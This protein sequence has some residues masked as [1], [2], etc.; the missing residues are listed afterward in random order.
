MRVG[1]ITLKLKLIH[2]PPCRAEKELR[3]PPK[4]ANKR[5]D[6]GHLKNKAT[7]KKMVP[8]TLVAILDID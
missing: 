5:Q 2:K 8:T 7:V 6:I 4:I 3:V 1:L